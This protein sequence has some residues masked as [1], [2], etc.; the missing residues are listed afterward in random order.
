LLNEQLLV[1]PVVLPS[2]LL[3]LAARLVWGAALGCPV[4]A[5]DRHSGRFLIVAWLFYLLLVWVWNPDYGGQRDWDLFSLVAIPQTLLLI[6]FLPRSL[7]GLRYLSLGAIPLIALQAM[8]TA[9]WIYQ[10]TLPWHWP[11]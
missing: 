8:H 3:L 11:E 4:G 7:A 6:Y 2:L 1:A 5:E 9:A 10:N